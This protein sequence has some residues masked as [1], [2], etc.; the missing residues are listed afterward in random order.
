MEKEHSILCDPN[1]FFG[2]KNDL[3]KVILILNN[4]NY[5][6]NNEAIELINDNIKEEF[7]IKLL[8]YYNEELPKILTE[9]KSYCE[10]NFSEY[11]NI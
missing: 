6:T 11:K 10:E 1:Y 4:K 2:R 3:R 8:N 7:K 5:H 9:V